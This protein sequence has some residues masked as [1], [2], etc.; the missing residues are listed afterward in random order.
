[1]IRTAFT[2]RG[3]LTPASTSRAAAP[4]TAG[5][6]KLVPVACSHDSGPKWEGIQIDDPGAAMSGFFR[7]PIVGPRALLVAMTS[8]VRV[9]VDLLW[10][11]ATLM[12]L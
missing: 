12:T 8:S 9:A 11:L 1:M 2:A 5:D 10:T 7:P 4:A 6:E 3:S